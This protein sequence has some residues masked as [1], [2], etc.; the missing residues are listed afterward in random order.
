[1]GAEVKMVSVVVQAYNSSDTIV[2]TLESIK[3]QTYPCIELIISDDLSTDNTLEGESGCAVCYEA[4]D[5]QE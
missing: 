2:Y 4:C 3:A 5:N 1:M